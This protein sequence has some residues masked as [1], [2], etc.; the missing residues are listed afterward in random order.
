MNGLNSIELEI[1]VNIKAKVPVVSIISYEEDR[2]FESLCKV[3]NHMCKHQQEVL[4]EQ[5]SRAGDEQERQQLSERLDVLASPKAYQIVK[6]TLTDGLVHYVKND[7]ENT[8]A[9]TKITGDFRNPIEAIEFLWKQKNMTSE[10][11]DYQTILFVFCD[12]HYWI[13]RNDRAG[14]F[15]VHLT[16]RLKDFSYW[17]RKKKAPQS[18]IFLSPVEVIPN[19][20]KTYMQIVN[21][22]IPSAEE[23]EKWLDKREVD[24]KKQYG[25]NCINLA[26]EERKK[27]LGALRGLTFEEAEYVV[28][29]S[30]TGNGVFDKNDIDVVLEEKRQII[31]KDGM[32]EYFDSDISIEQVGGLEILLRWL[33]RRKDAFYG[34]AIQVGEATIS[35]PM[36]KGVL[37]IGVSGCGKSLVAKAV[38]KNWKLPLL[39]L[40]IG[41]IFGGIVGQSEENMRKAIRIA[42]SI[43]PVIV[44]LD[45]IEKAFPRTN[46]SS[47]SGVSTRVMGTFLHW[48][49][50][51]KAPVFVVA[52][53][54]EIADLPPELTR[55]G[56]F[57]EIFY[58][59]LPNL[60]ARKEIIKI[61]S[62]TL[63]LSENHINEIAEKTKF[64]TG[65]EIEQTLKNALFELKGILEDNPDASPSGASDLLF[66]AI[67]KTM[68]DMV[69]LADRRVVKDGKKESILKDTIEK[70]Q[71]IAKPASDRFEELPTGDEHTRFEYK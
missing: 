1:A 68:E 62:L 63:P 17:F 65:A 53:G 40:D 30:M 61:H 56:R 31:Q 47:D 48:M 8:W 11:F 19:E 20:L 35:L 24:L 6:W 36:P 41:K 14:R 27:L 42:E 46:S 34:Q 16:R 70:A 32:L 15:N 59:G 37:L 43:A 28:E 29:K 23:L 10:V 52:T 44:W 3:A 50:E 67:R 69:P 38:A 49:Q 58:V 22:D 55:K 12:M 33:D 39:R 9:T 60:E 2:V 71:S 4:Q 64:Y 7:V 5:L 57:D 45:E 13:D 26:L 54:N 66:A 25:D 51:K 21:Y 18:L